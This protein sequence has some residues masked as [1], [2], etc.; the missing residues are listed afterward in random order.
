MNARAAISTAAAA[1]RV[2]RHAATLLAG[3]AVL[4]LATA[5]LYARDVGFHF[6]EFFFLD[7]A[8]TLAIHGQ[9]ATFSNGQLHPFDPYLSTGPTVIVPIAL[10]FRLFGVD[11][12]VARLVMVALMPLLF[13]LV[14]LTTRELHG[15]VAAVVAAGFLLCVPD[16]WLYALTVLGEV[17]A[18]LF[19][20]AAVLAM[21]RG[22]R[23]RSRLPHYALAGAL[24]GL[25]VLT[26]LVLALALGAFGVV[27]LWAR[28]REGRWCRALLA[29]SATALL[30][31]LSWELVQ[32][33]ALGPAAYLRM[34]GEFWHIFTLESGIDHWRAAGIHGWARSVA[35]LVVANVAALRGE[36]SLRVVPA[37]ALVAVVLLEALRGARL[38]TAHWRLHALLAAFLVPYLLWFFL[39]RHSPWFRLLVPAYLVC[40]L[41]VAAFLVRAGRTAYRGTRRHLD[42][43]RLAVAGYVVVDLC[44]IPF[45]LNVQEVAH[46]YRDQPAATDLQLVDAIR[47]RVPPEARI[48]YWGWLQAPE[49]AFFLPNEFYDV[50]QDRY[51]AALVPGQD[52]LLATRV[53][54]AAA[55]ETWTAQLQLC[56]ERLLS[57]AGAVLCQLG[58]GPGTP[59]SP[60]PQARALRPRA[61]ASGMA[62]P[63]FWRSR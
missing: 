58:P 41:Y 61:R 45:L 24:L 1:A 32:V 3:L 10:A 26:K 44:V 11:Y 30:V 12:L 9:Y 25:A 37:I 7:A 48:G 33:V 18:T 15:R 17:P 22:E 60:A 63:V 62:R 36:A 23:A 29:A 27:V 4:L 2:Q 35:E 55:P 34:R 31:L 59:S 51:R 50:S 14:Y 43:V 42:L 38:A 56:G 53:Q 57:R 54:R 46:T 21:V 39:A 40:A 8:R 28:V 49:I 13:A 6:D 5:T 47:Q 19:L 52:F 16:L 20:L